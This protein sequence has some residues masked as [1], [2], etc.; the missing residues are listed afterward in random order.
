M[1]RIL[2]DGN[3]IWD[4]LQADDGSD[5]DVL[6]EVL[7]STDVQG[8]ITQTDLDSLYR[9][10]AQEQDVAI[11]FK[12]VEQV[13]RILKVYSPETQGIDIALAGS[14]QPSFQASTALHTDL[15]NPETAALS[16]QGFLERYTLDLLYEG[17]AQP[18]GSAVQHWYRKWRQSGFD[19]MW[20]IPII[21]TLTLQNLPFLQQFIASLLPK[22][23]SPE[24][25]SQP[26]IA[27][28]LVPLDVPTTPA[29]NSGTAPSQEPNA[30]GKAPLLAD[31]PST[32][33]TEDL[34]W[35]L[36]GE[37]G[38]RPATTPLTPSTTGQPAPSSLSTAISRL[39][40]ETSISTIQPQ[41]GSSTSTAL[42]SPIA[43]APPLVAEVPFGRPPRSG[44]TP[45]GPKDTPALTPGSGFPPNPL[46]GSGSDGSGSDGSGSGKAGSDLG[47]DLGSD[48]SGTGDSGA[49]GSGSGS[50]S[51]SGNGGFGLGITVTP[52]EGGDP[53]NGGVIGTEPEGVVGGEGTP[54]T[55]GESGDS[56]SP[57]TDSGSSDPNSPENGRP[58]TAV[59]GDSTG[60]PNATPPETLEDPSFTPEQQQAIPET[61]PG[62]EPGV[63]LN[64][65]DNLLNSGNSAASFSLWNGDRLFQQVEGYFTPDASILQ[66]TPLY[67][68]DGFSP[69]SLTFGLASPGISLGTAPLDNSYNMAP[70]VLQGTP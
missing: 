17:D 40:T 7:Q 49:D 11:A 22:N 52:G 65:P 32:Q 3:L 24:G 61:I 15:L 1:K 70:P 31:A 35:V 58:G 25:A 33:R 2:L 44:K 46:I 18:A 21:L 63:M 14:L 53:S 50:G 41:P 23:D 6:W 36:R 67:T 39:F 68:L 69:P 26:Q 64:E 55:D 34:T 42:N 30:D 12:L 43:S 51:G 8:Y 27:Q 45:R 5:F 48:Y 10:I 38:D 57:G 4:A 59:G 28:G 62:L 66:Q 37:R 29:P 47:S 13:K 56:N 20:L 16:I 19:S 9:R 54:K 60:D